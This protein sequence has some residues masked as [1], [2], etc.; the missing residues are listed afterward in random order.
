MINY[1]DGG[2]SAVLRTLP[3]YVGSL[4]RWIYA[5]AHAPPC[6]TLLPYRVATSY[7]PKTLCEIAVKNEGAK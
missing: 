1:G 7:I 5:G 3:H 2:H 4:N 6:G